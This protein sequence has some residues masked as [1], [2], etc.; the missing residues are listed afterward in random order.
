MGKTTK[1]EP[2]LKWWTP[3][4]AQAKQHG[5]QDIENFRSKPRAELQPQ[6]Q[7]GSNK[8]FTT[9]FLFIFF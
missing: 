1:T 6:L 9:K 7:K 2:D 8:Q 3:Q 5:G 4:A